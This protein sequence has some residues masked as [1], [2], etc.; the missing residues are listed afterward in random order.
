MPVTFPDSIITGI[1]IFSKASCLPFVTL[2][3]GL[4]K[5]Q[6]LEYT[7]AVKKLPDDCIALFDPCKE[8]QRLRGWQRQSNVTDLHNITGAIANYIRWF[9]CH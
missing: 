5:C 7:V 8:P 4:C 3:E 9:K 1:I 2:E 6:V